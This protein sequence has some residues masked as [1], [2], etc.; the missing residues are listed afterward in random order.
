[1]WPFVEQAV[2]QGFSTR[3][4]LE[5]GSTLPDG[6]PVSSNANL[7]RAAVLMRIQRGNDLSP[8][9]AT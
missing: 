9:T 8:A 2:R 3:V 7:V 1:M 5:D 6:A 4:G